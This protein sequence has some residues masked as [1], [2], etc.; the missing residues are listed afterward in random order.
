M[1]GKLGDLIRKVKK[2]REVK[3]YKKNRAENPTVV[4]KPHGGKPGPNQMNFSK[5]G[6]IQHD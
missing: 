1:P 3:K 2:N 5:G 4:N 6:L